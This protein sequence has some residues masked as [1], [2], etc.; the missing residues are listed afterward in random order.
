MCGDILTLLRLLIEQEPYLENLTPL[1]ALQYSMS[2]YGHPKT[3]QN[4]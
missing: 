3:E 2:S 4:Q 1:I